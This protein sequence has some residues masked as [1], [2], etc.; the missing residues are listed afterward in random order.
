MLWPKARTLFCLS[1]CPTLA[2]PRREEKKKPKSGLFKGNPTW[3][4]AWD[5]YMLQVTCPRS[6]TV[7]SWHFLS[8]HVALGKFWIM[9]L[10]DW[11]VIPA[12]LRLNPGS[13]ELVQ[14]GLQFADWEIC[15]TPGNSH[16]NSSYSDIPQNYEQKVFNYTQILKLYDYNS[17]SSWVR[18]CFSNEKKAVLQT[19]LQVTLNHVGKG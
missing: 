17:N 19:V 12:N 1:G 2:L 10:M 11:M 7:L 13:L 16:R 14:R 5:R 9:L 15:M 3:L 18:Q 8:D 6:E 4:V